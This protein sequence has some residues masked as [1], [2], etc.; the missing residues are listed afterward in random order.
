MTDEYRFRGRC[1]ACKTPGPWRETAEAARE[2]ADNHF[3][4][5]H[6]NN[7]LV[8]RNTRVQRFPAAEVTDA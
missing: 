5:D 7:P 1:D 3:D 4:D 8:D 2:W 6:P